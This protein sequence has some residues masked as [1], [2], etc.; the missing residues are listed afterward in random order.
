[1]ADDCLDLMEN[2]QLE[3]LEL[4]P[5]GSNYTFLA[6]ICHE[7]REVEVVYKPRKGERPLWDFPAGSL[8]LRER[9]AFLVSQA[10]GWDIVPPTILRDGPHGLGAVQSFVE[11][12][13]NQHYFTFQGQYQEQL[14]KFALFDLV[15][16]NAD[17]KGG[18]V[19]LDDTGRLWSIDHGICFH[20]EAKLRTVIWDFAGQPIPAGLLANLVTLLADLRTP[21]SKLFQALGDLLSVAEIEATGKRANRLVQSKRFPEPGSGRYYPWP[22]V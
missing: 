14:Q 12:D 9:A 22:P 13:P 2:G 7:Q 10:L 5:W 1:M 17:R 19:L 18:H 8:C 3:L 21:G 20:L 16:N 4:L 6:R 11:H 15:A